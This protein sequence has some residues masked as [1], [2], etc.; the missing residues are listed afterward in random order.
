MRS[1]APCGGPGGIPADRQVVGSSLPLVAALLPRGVQPRHHTRRH[2]IRTNEQNNL[3]APRSR[4]TGR[5]APINPTT[6][7][8]G[9]EP[10]TSPSRKTL[11][12]MPLLDRNR[13]F[14]FNR[15][16]NIV[17]VFQ[18]GLFRRA[19]EQKH[20][21]RHQSCNDTLRLGVMRTN[22]C[23]AATAL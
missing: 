16:L 23:N 15:G 13:S 10:S 3:T 4:K 14:L 22:Q 5:V 6:V 8:D 18:D 21:N 12:C 20:W 7:L 1:S 11:R 2:S 19:L 9:A 17:K